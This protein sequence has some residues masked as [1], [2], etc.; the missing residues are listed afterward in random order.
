MYSNL[1]PLCSASIIASNSCNFSASKGFK[2]LTLVVGSDGLTVES[3]G[4]FPFESVATS[5]PLLSLLSFATLTSLAFTFAVGTS[6][7]T[8]PFKI[9]AYSAA[10]VSITPAVAVCSTCPSTPSLISKVT[11]PLIL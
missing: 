2:S 4:V 10:G 8:T 6:L 1:C 11:V 5:L 3:L 7:P 9:L